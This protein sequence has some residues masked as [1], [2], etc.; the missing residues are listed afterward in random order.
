MLAC[1]PTTFDQIV[2]AG[3]AAVWIS[4]KILRS[5]LHIRIYG[6]IELLS[7]ASQMFYGPRLGIQ[8]FNL[9]NCGTMSQAPSLTQAGHPVRGNS[10][11]RYRVPV[12]DKSPGP[13]TSMWLLQSL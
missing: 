11:C 3:G 9:L 4:C 5:E 13:F 8:R 7:Q 10:C 12:E 1:T 2:P 6:F